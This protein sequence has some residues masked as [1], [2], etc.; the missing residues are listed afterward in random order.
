[1]TFR[2]SS[3]KTETR[4]EPPSILMERRVGINR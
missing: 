3:V 4:S 2:D 1:M